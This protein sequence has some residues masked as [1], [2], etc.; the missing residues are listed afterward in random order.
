MRTKQRTRVNIRPLTLTNMYTPTPSYVLNGTNT[1]VY[2]HI[3]TY[4]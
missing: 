4:S 1:D 2:V 3:N